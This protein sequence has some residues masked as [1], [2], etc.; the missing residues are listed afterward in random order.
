[1]DLSEN[2]WD[3][4][5]LSGEETSYDTELGKNFSH[6]KKVLLKTNLR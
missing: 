2:V 3:C 6:R 1:M 4:L 5:F